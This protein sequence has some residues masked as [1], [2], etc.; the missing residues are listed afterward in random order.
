MG[1]R[2]KK[3]L[4]WHMVRVMKNWCIW[5]MVLEKTLESPLDCKEI[6]TV[7]PKGNQ[8]WIFIRRTDAEAEAPIL[9]SPAMKS[10]LIRKDLDAG[11][12][13]RQKEKGVAEDEMVGWHHWISG[14]KFEQTPGNSEGQGSLACCSPWGCRVRKD[15]VTEQQPPIP[16]LPTH[17]PPCVSGS[18]CLFYAPQISGI[19]VFV[20]LWWG[21]FTEYNVLKVLSCCSRH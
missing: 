4:K 3:S 18:L 16:L 5:T 17:G 12:D 10:R 13:W 1:T 6:Q 19:T 15:W 14:H 11:K 2:G 8:P 20:L 7:N 9:W 21:H